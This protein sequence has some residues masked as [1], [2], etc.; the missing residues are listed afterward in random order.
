[1]YRGAKEKKRKERK[2]E[3]RGKKRGTSKKYRCK[4]LSRFMPTLIIIGIIIIIIIILSMIRL[5]S[6]ASLRTRFPLENNSN[7]KKENEWACKRRRET[8]KR[9]N[10]W[11]TISLRTPEGRKKRVRE[12]K[13][14]R[15][16]EREKGKKDGN[17]LPSMQ[18][19]KY[20][21][22]FLKSSTKIKSLFERLQVVGY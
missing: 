9:V 18:R 1:M 16:R 22:S 17:R 6:F 19:T 7:S 21:N 20:I 13:R 2:K 8:D 15:E 12:R 4:T 5:S 14:G 3:K 11:C 10:C